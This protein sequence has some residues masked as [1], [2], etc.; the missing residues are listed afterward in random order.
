MSN[1]KRQQP[2][3]QEKKKQDLWTE[4]EVEAKRIHDS[5]FDD[6]K[7]SHEKGAGNRNDKY[8]KRQ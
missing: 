3:Q 6:W 1:Q 4:E 7:D 2:P 8:F 5:N